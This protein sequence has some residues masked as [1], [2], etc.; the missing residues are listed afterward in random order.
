LFFLYFCSREKPLALYV[1]SKDENAFEHFKSRTSSGSFV[2]NDCLVQ[3]GVE[4]LPFGGVGNSGIGS[5]HGFYAFRNFSHQR[6]IVKA[7]FF[8]DFLSK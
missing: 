1:F 5:Y 2:F 7:S 3:G 8:G 6:A 4:A